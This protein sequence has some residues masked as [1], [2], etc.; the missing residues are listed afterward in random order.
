MNIT[1]LIVGNLSRNLEM[2]KTTIADFSDAELLVRPTPAANHAAWQLGHL[3]NAETSIGN[4]LR[5]GSMPAL[6]LGFADRF[7]G[8]TTGIDDPKAMA[9]KEE[10]LHLLTQARNG[11]IAWAKALSPQEM[12]APTPERMRRFAPTLAEAAL[13]Q[14]SHMTMHIGQLQVIR[15]KLGKPIL[16]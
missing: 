7:T 14:A 12:D 16:F 10:L 4:N 5:P 3:V 8:K 13:G 15:R 11:T 9:T 1:D 6:P 2:L